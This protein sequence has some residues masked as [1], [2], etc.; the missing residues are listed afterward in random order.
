ML[1]RIAALYRHPVKGF[2]PEP[3]PRVRLEA[4][5]FFPADRMFALENGPSGF[6]E[7]APRHI[8]KFA[9]AVLATLPQLVRVR[10]WFDEARG[11]LHV[12]ADGGRHAAFPLASAQG[13]QAFA[14]WVEGFLGK[15]AVDGPLKLTLAPGHRFTD[16]AQGHVSLINL[17]SVRALERQLG[18]AVDPLRFRAN[19]HVDGWPAWAELD[20]ARGHLVGAGPARLRGFKRTIRCIATHA[21]P[22]T[23]VRDLDLC[24]E[25]M[26]AYGHAFFGVYLNVSTGGEIA[27]GDAA[28]TE[29]EP[30]S[31]LNLA[32]AAPAGQ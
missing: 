28:E 24:G 10:T 3:L 5:G 15:G 19:I 25:M 12:S 11:V 20:L 27:V 26:R 8:S 21:D 6:D 18:V 32:P 16:H 1:G 22:Q 17:E 31:A 9:F 2:T 7:A 29:Y 23:G 4:G 13:R 14:D 30:T